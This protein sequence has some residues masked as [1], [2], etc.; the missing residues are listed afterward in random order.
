MVGV[1]GGLIVLSLT[2]LKMLGGSPQTVGIVGASRLTREQCLSLSAAPRRRKLDR[3]RVGTSALTNNGENRPRGHSKARPAQEVWPTLQEWAPPPTA[4]VVPL[5]RG[6]RLPAR[7][8]DPGGEETMTLELQAN[9]ISS[10][11]ADAL[12]L[13][14]YRLDSLVKLRYATLD[15]ARHP[16]DPAREVWARVRPLLDGR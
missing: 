15:A 7:A 3:M 14:R 16:D 1:A 12:V 4:A 13:D 11:D 10:S 6:G 8:Q 5:T 2:G 9:R